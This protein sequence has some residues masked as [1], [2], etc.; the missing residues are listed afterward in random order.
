MHYYELKPLTNPVTN[1]QSM[2]AVATLAEIWEEKVQA[3]RDRKE[4][5]DLFALSYLAQNDPSR[6]QRLLRKV[7]NEASPSASNMP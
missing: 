2:V 5:G 3:L 7:L 1:V 6:T 4:A